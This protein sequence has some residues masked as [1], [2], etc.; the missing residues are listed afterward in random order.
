MPGER[1]YVIAYD[2]GHPK[3]WRRVFKMM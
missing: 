3:R 2:I 1:L